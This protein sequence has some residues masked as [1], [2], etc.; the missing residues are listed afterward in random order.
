MRLIRIL[1]ALAI[2]ALVPVL[3][4]SAAYAEL[5]GPCTATGTING[6]VYDPKIDDLAV[7]PRAGVIHWRGTVASGTGKRN[8]E[9][10]VYLKLPPPFG[11][12]I[13]GNG[14]WDG[15]SSRDANS[16]VYTY[17]LPAVLVGPKLTVF[18]HHSERG[19][20]VCTASI[21]VQIVG[22]KLKNPAF[23]ASLLLT[24]LALINVGVVMRV[25]ASR[26]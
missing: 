11:H 20:V 13:I 17:D 15:L 24:V 5:A 2:I 16:G 9:G 3:T 26:I 21:D 25:K 12:A 7:V 8:I 6:R 23:V 19:N 1:V 14:S 22:S 10:K 4:A 18:G